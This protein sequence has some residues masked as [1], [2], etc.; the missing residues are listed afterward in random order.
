M[1]TGILE[2][3]QQDFARCD[4]KRKDKWKTRKIAGASRDKLSW[5]WADSDSDCAYTYLDSDTQTNYSLCVY[6]F[7]HHVPRILPLLLQWS[8]E[9]LRKVHLILAFRVVNL[10]CQCSLQVNNERIYE[11]IYNLCIY[12]G[13]AGTQIV[14]KVQCMWIPQVLI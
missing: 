14:E 7:V 10:M 11:C 13:N 6:G 9:A 4:D 5:S 8:C 3:N 1:F 12:W 2:E